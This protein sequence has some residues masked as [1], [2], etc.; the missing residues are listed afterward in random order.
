MAARTLGTNAS[1]V[2]PPRRDGQ[3]APDLAAIVITLLTGCRSAPVP[4]R[5]RDNPP[6]R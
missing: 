3:G 5:P 2:P 6:R 4:A 1:R